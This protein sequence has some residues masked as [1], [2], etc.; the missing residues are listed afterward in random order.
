MVAVD[1]FTSTATATERRKLS[2]FIRT[3]RQMANLWLRQLCALAKVSNPYLSQVERGLHDP[4]VRVPKSIGEA[5]NVMSAGASIVTKLKGLSSVGA[6]VLAATIGWARMAFPDV[7]CLMCALPW[8]YRLRDC[9]HHD[10]PLNRSRRGPGGGLPIGLS[11]RY[12]PAP[13]QSSEAESPYPTSR[14]TP[15]QPDTT[16]GSH[17]WMLAFGMRHHRWADS[18]GRR[19]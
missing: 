18:V 14:T 16:E 2:G 7:I 4:S 13:E 17:E 1:G 15:W 9:L 8:K 5:L 6:I 10:A 3:Q 12:S 19:R 11:P